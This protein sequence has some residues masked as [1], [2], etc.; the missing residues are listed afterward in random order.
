MERLNNDQYFT[1]RRLVDSLGN[2]LDIIGD[3][4]DYVRVLEPCCGNGLMSD[5]LIDMGCEVLS[6]DIDENL[7]YPDCYLDATVPYNLPRGW[8]RPDW[9][10]T[11]PPYSQPTCQKIIENAYDR[12]QIGIAMLLRLSYLEPCRGRAEFLNSAWLSHLIIFN[13]R[14]RFRLDTKGSDNCTVAWFVWRKGK[15][16]GTQVINCTNWNNERNLRPYPVGATGVTQRAV[17]HAV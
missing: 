9:V 6:A 8:D 1:D 7:D 3:C 14:P 5:A 15:G 11:N 17:S 16:H 2:H 10:I 12:C 4:P 13:P